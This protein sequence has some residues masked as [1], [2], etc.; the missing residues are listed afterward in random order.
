[1]TVTEKLLD[2][3]AERGD[4]LLD[5]T[6]RLDRINTLVTEWRDARRAFLALPPGDPTAR[7]ARQCRA[8][9]HERGY[10]MKTARDWAY[11]AAG[12]MI[13]NGI[14]A[15]FGGAPSVGFIVTAVCLIFMGGKL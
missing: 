13:G 12:S 7:A 6:A 10:R 2:I 8:R 14:Y 15:M 4:R 9:A 5:Y 11:A 1:M 3:I